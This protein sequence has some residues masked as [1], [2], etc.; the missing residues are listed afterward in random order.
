[1]HILELGGYDAILG[2][3]WLAQCGEMTCQWQDKWIRFQH[4]GQKITLQGMHDHPV[5]QELTE[6]FVEQIVKW[7][8][9]NE[10]WAAAVL[11][12]STQVVHAHPPE[13]VQ[14]LLNRFSSV[15]GDPKL[16]P[17]HRQYD[18]SIHILPDVPPVNSKPYRYAPFQKNEIEKQVKE[19]LAAG[20]IVPSISLYAS[21][22]LLV[23]KKDGTW[24]F[25][26]IG[27]SML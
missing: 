6:V 9:G 21:P 7:Q 26:T 13:A 11:E 2:M 10:V 16:L 23:K 20:I 4:Q 19:M 12:P 18:H 14:A 15:F 3:D 22:V 5:L 17:P 25:C 27:G 24:R 1:M 8:K